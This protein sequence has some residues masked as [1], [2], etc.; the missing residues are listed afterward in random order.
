MNTQSFHSVQPRQKKILNT[1]YSQPFE[2]NVKPTIGLLHSSDVLTDFLDSLNITLETFCQDF[3]ESWIFGYVDALN[4]VGVRTVLFCISL[5][6]DKPSYFI[7]QATGTRICLLPPWPIYRAYRRIAV[8]GLQSSGGA[9]G[10]N[11]KEIQNRN[12]LR[13]ALLNP[14]KTMAKSVGSY[15]STPWGLLA[16]ELRRENCQAILC[17]EYEYARFDSSVL[18]GKW[19]GL[20]TFATFQ[21]GDRTKSWIEVPGR[22]LAM[23]CCNGAIVGNPTEFQRIRDRY[24]IPRSKIA[25]IFNP[26]EVAAWQGTDRTEARGALGI[27]L[28]AE[29]AVWHGRVELDPQGLDLLLAAWQQVC[30]DRPDRDLRLLILGPVHNPK[31]FQQRMDRMPLRGVIWFNQLIRDRAVIKQ[32]LGASD[33]YAFPSGQEGFPVAPVEAMCCGLP[34]VATDVPGIPDILEHGEDSGG[35]VVPRGDVSAFAIALGRLLDDRPWS[36]KIGCRAR[37]RAE[38]CFS[39]ETIG[40]Q[41]RDVLLPHAVQPRS[42]GSRCENH[43]ARRGGI[44]GD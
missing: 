1:G 27:P 19:M 5:R 14:L 10:K 44:P 28:D 25:R 12:S 16:Q 9:E 22:Y 21:G 41:L 4:R 37:S 35:I 15:L 33:V 24:W 30:H 36:E 31:A 3:V 39:P 13:H 23:H 17:Q 34:V 26:L 2:P 32:Y 18:L 43:L 20:P 42:V 38:R 40:K 6:V 7:H 29:V 11:C 8:K